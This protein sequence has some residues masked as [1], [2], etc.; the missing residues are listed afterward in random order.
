MIEDKSKTFEEI[1]NEWYKKFL[2]EETGMNEKIKKAKRQREEELSKAR[3]E[4]KETIKQYEIQQREKLESDKD[5]LN[6]AKNYFDQMDADHKKDV[7]TMKTQL[8]QN[9]D[10]VID[11]LISNVMNV[12]LDLPASVLKDGNERLGQANMIITD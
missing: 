10:K 4:A 1:F 6:V 8:K 7:D 5:K 11:F 2:E 12:E 9:K 3:E